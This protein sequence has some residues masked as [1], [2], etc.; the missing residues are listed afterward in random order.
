MK[1]MM[2][3]LACTAAFAVSATEWGYV[4]FEGFATGAFK[5]GS[6]DSKGVCQNSDDGNFLY[7]ASSGSTDGSS[8][9]AYDGAPSLPAGSPKTVGEHYLS[10]ST[11]GG[12]LWRYLNTPELN[13]DT[14][15][16]LGTWV[17]TEAVDASENP[18]YIDTMVQ[19]TATEDGSE[20]DVGEDAKLAIWLN[21]ATDESGASTT[22]LCVRGACLL[23]EEFAAEAATFTLVAED[24]TS[25]SVVPGTWYRLTVKALTV[26]D[27]GDEESH[28]VV[29]GFQ[30]MLDGKD[31]KA[32]ENPFSET[33]LG[34]LT[35]ENGVA[36]GIITLVNAGKVIPS[37]EDSV[38]DSGSGISDKTL[39]L[40][41]VGFKG[42]GAIDEF[43][44]TDVEPSFEAVI[45]TVDFTLAW[46]D[47][48]SAVKYTIDGGA[49]QE[50]E[51]NKPF[52]VENGKTVT[53]AATAA[54]WYAIASGTGDFTVNG[55][56]TVTVTAALAESP[57]ALGISADGNIKTADLKA[58][59]DGKGLKIDQVKAS[60]FVSESFFLNTDTLLTSAPTLKIEDV[61]VTD[62]GKMNIV[63]SATGDGKSV[64]MEKINGG[65]YIMYSD[66]LDALKV[67]TRSIAGAD[68]V[69]NDGKATV[70]VDGGKFVKVSVE[71]K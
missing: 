62:D 70:T 7:E 5:Y 63:V 35:E 57:N 67:A 71:A 37:L 4:G 53:V 17:P 43:L 24:G 61:K 30:V 1:K 13:E 9:V 51:N 66:T 68:L 64:D 11:E 25:P 49:E 16:E 3:A 59:A 26:C 21:V 20:P 56:Q 48:V 38:R 44:A 28:S 23:D 27:W 31:L 50:A 47:G 12:T 10:L 32:K 60:S 54:D 40:T 18:I 52:T 33:V 34:A 2:L 46:G 65:L 69:A 58:W 8:V 45:T 14:E 22:N 55:K 39:A 41:A 6:A 42:S 15:V 36:P 29:A 19:F